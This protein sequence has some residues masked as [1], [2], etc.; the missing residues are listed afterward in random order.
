MNRRKEEGKKI[1]KDEY[2]DGKRRGRRDI[3]MNRWKEGKKN[4]SMEVRKGRKAGRRSH[5]HRHAFLSPLP[6]VVPHKFPFRGI[7]N[8][9][10]L[11]GRR[12]LALALPLARIR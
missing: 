6:P 2:K 10:S 3:K 1:R 8:V 9:F 5:P 7:F 11:S 12:F 4:N